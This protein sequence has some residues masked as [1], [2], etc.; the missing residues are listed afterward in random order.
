MFEDKMASKEEYF[1]DW[2]SEKNKENMWNTY[3]IMMKKRFY[4][5]RRDQAIR[6]YRCAAFD[7]NKEFVCENAIKIPCNRSLPTVFGTRTSEFSTI[8]ICGHWDT[9]KKKG[10]KNRTTCSEGS[11]AAIPIEIKDTVGVT[12]YEY[13]KKREALKEGED[14]SDLNDFSDL[15]SVIKGECKL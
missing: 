5:R 2:D 14:R 3:V 6:F 15:L 13:F 10:K 8:Y 1:K 12:D 9:E 7:T 4:R 11:G